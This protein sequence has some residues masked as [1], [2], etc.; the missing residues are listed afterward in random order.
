MVQILS[1]HQR[2]KLENQNSGVII[3]FCLNNYEMEKSEPFKIKGKSLGSMLLCAGP[4][5][6]WTGLHRIGSN[7]LE[8]W[9]QVISLLKLWIV[10]SRVY[11]NLLEENGRNPKIV[12]FCDHF[13]IESVRQ[14]LV[15]C[16][17]RNQFVAGPILAL[18]P[19]Q[20]VEE[21]EREREREN[22]EGIELKLS[23]YPKKEKEN[24]ELIASEAQKTYLYTKVYELIEL[25]L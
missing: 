21:D 12:S 22:L 10:R 11:L 6:M 20:V 15:H 1:H 8:H 17:D 9:T 2:L 16:V 23:F 25:I 5:T 7:A 14:F 24:S 4:D 19:W 18:I 13:L 3:K